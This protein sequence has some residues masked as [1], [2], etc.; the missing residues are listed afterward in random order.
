MLLARE[1]VQ[2]AEV[3]AVVVVILAA[4]VVVVVTVILVVAVVV[5]PPALVLSPLV[6]RPRMQGV[7]IGQQPMPQDAE[8]P[9]IE[10]GEG[11]NVVI[12]VREIDDDARG[13]E[14]DRG[15]DDIRH[16]R[17]LPTRQITPT[18]PIRLYTP[19]P[20]D[21]IPLRAARGELV[22]VNGLGMTHEWDGQDVDQNRSRL[23]TSEIWNEISG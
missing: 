23:Q 18:R 6:R 12:H 4:V 8:A 17:P 15:G 1:I 2:A 19:C 9:I 10:T 22:A 3:V 16:Y 13:G 21:S 11:A 20:Q 14:V 7:P 5:T